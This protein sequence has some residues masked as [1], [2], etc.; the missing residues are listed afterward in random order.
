[1]T[2]Q[3]LGQSCMHVHSEAF[4]A[5]SAIH[6]RVVAP[7]RV[8]FDTNA[9]NTTTI[10]E[11]RIGRRSDLQLDAV[12]TITLLSRLCAHACI[13]AATIRE[14]SVGHH[15][16]FDA[17]TTTLPW[18]P[19]P[20][21]WPQARNLARAVA[22]QPHHARATARNPAPPPASE[23]RHCKQARSIWYWTLA[24]S[25]APTTRAHNAPALAR[26]PRPATW[27]RTPPPAPTSSRHV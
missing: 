15:M 11:R 27:L 4:Q 2:A 17:T 3:L 8:V 23:R 16:Y 6:H 1:M 13:D 26:S 14:S 5:Q 22:T 18:R 7:T 21:R 9:T 10:R 25:L 19:V 20:G 24:P 12:T